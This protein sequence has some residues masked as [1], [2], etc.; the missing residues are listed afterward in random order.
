MKTFIERRHTKTHEAI[1]Y[2]KITKKSR[3]K[4]KINVELDM[5]IHCVCVCVGNVPS[6]KSFYLFRIGVVIIESFCENEILSTHTHTK[7][8]SH[9]NAH[10]RSG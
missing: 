5:N 10:T 6:E 2:D 9:A 4:I 1:H 3:T 7:K 8:K